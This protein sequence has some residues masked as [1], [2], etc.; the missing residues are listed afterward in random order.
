MSEAANDNSL[1]SPFP[2]DL[3]ANISA[4]TDVDLKRSS[5]VSRIYGP[6]SSEHFDLSAPV[7]G[8]HA[9]AHPRALRKTMH[10]APRPFPPPA[11]MNVPVEYI[12][13]QLHALAPHYWSKPETA[14]CSLGMTFHSRPI[15]WR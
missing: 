10:F 4:S 9:P 5:T 8:V 7:P 12:I 2:A 11:L 15:R 1:F 6:P 3:Q 13:D 14:D